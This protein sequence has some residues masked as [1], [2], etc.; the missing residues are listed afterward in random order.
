M[1]AQNIFDLTVNIGLRPT[2]WEYSLLMDGYCLVGK[3][4]I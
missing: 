1:D 2:V 4:N 3:M